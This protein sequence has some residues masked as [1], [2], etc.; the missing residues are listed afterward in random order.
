V[1]SIASLGSEKYISL[2]TFRRDGSGV[3]TPV[4]V[5]ADHDHLYVITDA[6][7]GKAKRLANFARVMVAPC[8]MRGTV[9][10]ASVDAT[11]ELLDAAG[12]DRVHQLLTAKYGWKARLFT[13]MSRI[14]H[15]RS[16]PDRI[17][18]RITLT[19]PRLGLAGPD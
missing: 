13:T 2:T 9:T 7:S 5:M 10:G 16:S 11:A 8:D 12:T 14:R 18:I 19:T 3:A 1:T 4:W 17:G 15:P 6:A